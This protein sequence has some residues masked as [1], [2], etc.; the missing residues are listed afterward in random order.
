MVSSFIA[1]SLHEALLM[2]KE[3]PELIPYAGGTDLMLED[4]IN[5]NFLFLHRIPE[6][7]QIKEDGEYIRFGAACTFSEVIESPHT[8]ELLREACILIAA[9]AIRNIGTLGGN[10]GNG[11]PKADSA[12]VFMVTKSMLRLASAYHERIVPIREFYLGRKRL[13]L[14]PDELIVEVLLPKHGIGNYYFKK[15]GARKALAISRISFAG[16][17]DIQEGIIQNCATAFGSIGDIIICLED[18]DQMLIGK[19]IEEASAL[20][21]AYINAFDSAIIPTSGRVGAEYRKD[22]C[23]NL[24]SDFLEVN[25]I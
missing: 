7:K 21:D 14:A 24:L 23:M 16:I 13:A 11:S 2:R 3:S 18:I 12:L 20:K 8:P 15:V 4:R 5:S 6:M 19:S 10:I 9:P 1:G 17:M 25:G 22:V